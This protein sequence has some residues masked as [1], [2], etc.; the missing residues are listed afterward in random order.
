MAAALS[1]NGCP[2]ALRTLKVAFGFGV[3]ITNQILLG[4]LCFI[5]FYFVFTKKKERKKCLLDLR[6]TQ[7]S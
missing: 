7:D 3:D 1:T 5:V 4:K 2:G 6:F